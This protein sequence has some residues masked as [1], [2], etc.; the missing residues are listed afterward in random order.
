MIKRRIPRRILMAAA[1]VGL[2]LLD[3][4]QHVHIVTLGYEIEQ[5][6]EKQKELEQIHRQ[7]LI[8][9]ETLSALD[10]IEQIAVSKL[11]MTKPREGQIVLVQMTPPSGSTPGARPGLRVVKQIAE[12]AP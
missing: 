9:V 12:R 6:Q 3:I 11:G 7:L 2:I 4:W 8:E 10:R 5:T 1:V